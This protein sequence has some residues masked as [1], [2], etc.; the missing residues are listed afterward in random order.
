M[1]GGT[2]G[3]ELEGLGVLGDRE[4]AELRRGRAVRTPPN[5]PSQQP[6]ATRLPSGSAG[7]ATSPRVRR[8][9]QRLS[10]CTK[11]LPMETCFAA[12]I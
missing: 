11:H 12:R 1:H 3:A 6:M 4:K 5:L 7:P 10:Y 9:A 2:L 8:L